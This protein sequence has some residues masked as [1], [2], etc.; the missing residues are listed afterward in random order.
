MKE[1]KSLLLKD[2]KLSFKS[3]VYPVNAEDK[4]CSNERKHE[5]ISKLSNVHNL[6]FV[7]VQQLSFPLKNITS[8][9]S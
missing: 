1:L 6:N 3:H 2:P 4:K 9:D 5:K 7:F 8:A